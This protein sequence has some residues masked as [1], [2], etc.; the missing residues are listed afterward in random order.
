MPIHK[1]LYLDQHRQAPLSGMVTADDGERWDSLGEALNDLGAVGFEVQTP[2]Y[3]PAPGHSSVG[4]WVEAFLVV[5]KSFTAMQELE[6]RLARARALL[7]AA[8]GQLTTPT[9]EMSR[10]LQAINTGELRG[11]LDTIEQRLREVQGA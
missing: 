10:S 4:Q 5:H 6:R 7:A 8:E 2:I 1:L 9:S 11:Q 3:G